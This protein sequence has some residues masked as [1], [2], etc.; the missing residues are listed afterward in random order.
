[1]EGRGG[2][3][4]GGEGRRGRRVEGTREE[5]RRGGEGRGEEERRSS[6]LLA[7]IHNDVVVVL[8]VGQW[9]LGS[10]RALTTT[11]EVDRGRKLATAKHIHNGLSDSNSGIFNKAL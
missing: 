5:G 4:R 1:M 6:V 7:T 10:C 9:N 8:G 11:Q 3:G 2:E